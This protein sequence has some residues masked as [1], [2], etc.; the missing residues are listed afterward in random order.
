MDSNFKDKIS[1]QT[2]LRFLPNVLESEPALEH[3]QVIKDL[4]GA[5]VEQTP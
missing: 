5:E 3:F 1:V 2:H 4:R